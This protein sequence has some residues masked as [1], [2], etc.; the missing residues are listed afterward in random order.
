MYI[1]KPSREHPENF[2]MYLFY[3]RSSQNC[4]YKIF[5]IINGYLLINHSCDPP[6]QITF[7][8][9]CT[10]LFLR[11]A[12]FKILFIPGVLNLKVIFLAIFSLQLYYLLRNR[13][14]HLHVCEYTCVYPYMCVP[15][16]VCAYTC[17]PLHV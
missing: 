12:A 13:C 17:V 4:E 6:Y 7:L 1:T 16:H 3:F 11:H 2:S 15:I 10:I 5:C 14:E 8:I 9:E